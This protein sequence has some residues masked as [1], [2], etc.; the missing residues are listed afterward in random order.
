M[1]LAEVFSFELPGDSSGETLVSSNP[2]ECELPRECTCWLVG[3]V[4]VF[5]DKG[6]LTGGGGAG[7]CRFLRSGFCA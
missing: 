6:L 4:S 5:T 7:A 3:N 2:L 1:L